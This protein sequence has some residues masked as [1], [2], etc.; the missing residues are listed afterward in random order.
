M[1]SQP[2]DGP[3][4]LH[5]GHRQDRL[6]GAHAGALSGWR[7]TDEHP[8]SAA[9]RAGRI[10]PEEFAAG[11]FYRK[12]Y[13]IKHRSGRDSTQL[14]VTGARGEEG[15]LRVTAGELLKLV[16][17]RLPPGPWLAI[18]RNFCGC[19]STAGDACRAA[20]IEDRREHWS[21]I[22]LALSK[23]STAIEGTK[24]PQRVEEA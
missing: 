2:V 1:T 14:V 19:G 12:W 5:A 21:T 13:E 16:D 10:D 24:F 15:D 7:N 3:A 17:R 22:R 9:Y 8:L 23:L 18:V 20:A 11:E 4:K 6:L